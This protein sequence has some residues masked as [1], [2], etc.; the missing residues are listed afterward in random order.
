MKR[1][2]YLTLTALILFGCSSGLK[3][4]IEKEAAAS[5]NEKRDEMSSA[6][7]LYYMENMTWRYLSVDL[8][9]HTGEKQLKYLT[10]A[11]L[12]VKSSTLEIEQE[13]D[14]NIPVVPDLLKL[15]VVI[16]GAL[17]EL[18]MGDK[19]TK[20]D[21]SVKIG[22]IIGDISREYI[23]GELPPTTKR[24]TGMENAND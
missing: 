5:K 22:Q 2:I 12:D 8:F 4:E 16:E 17:N 14:S 7:I 24:L 15:G 1:L 9:S 21:N 3:K 23:E 13:F 19:S 18:L 11:A 20:Y 6:E 10:E